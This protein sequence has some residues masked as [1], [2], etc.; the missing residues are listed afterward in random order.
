MTQLI[1][2]LQYKKSEKGEFAQIAPRNLQDTLK[3]IQEYPWATERSLASVELTCP[4]VTI[5][6]PTGTYLKLGHYFSGKFCLYYLDSR[7]KVYFKVAPTLQEASEWITDFFEKDGHIEGFEKYSFTWS[8]ASYFIT[9]T[10]EYVVDRMASLRFFKFWQFMLVAA[11]IILMADSIDRSRPVAIESIAALM[12]FVIFLAGPHIYFYFN[13][14]S[15]DKNKYLQL[16]RAADQFRFGPAGKEKTLSKRE[17]QR[18]EVHGV[19]GRGLWNDCFVY[20]I[21]LKN[22]ESF[23]FTSLL[24]RYSVFQNKFP[25]HEAKRIK[26]NFPTV[27]RA[28]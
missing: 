10:F 25:D 18:I 19:F 8:R 22:G 9:D 14:R 20:V 6:H 2:K 1:S 28:V 24:M 13:Y 7:K 27:G 15:C 4:S 23:T 17:I 16:S 26:N 5:E 12:L 21:T 3:L 11:V